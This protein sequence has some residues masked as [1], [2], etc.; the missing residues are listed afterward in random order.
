VA[1]IAHR[2]PHLKGQACLPV[3]KSG[4]QKIT[5]NW[6]WRSPDELDEGGK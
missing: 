5:I 2:L 4:L 6:P 1:A 3:E